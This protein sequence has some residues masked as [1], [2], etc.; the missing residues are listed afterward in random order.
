MHSVSGGT[1]QRISR[2]NLSK[3]RGR[4]IDGIQKLNETYLTFR[5]HSIHAGMAYLTIQIAEE[6]NADMLDH[7]EQLLADLVKERTGLDVIRDALS[8]Q[9]IEIRSKIATI[10]Q[11]IAS[12]HHDHATSI[13]G[14]TN[15][16]MVNLAYLTEVAKEIIHQGNQCQA[17][18]REEGA[19]AIGI[20][21]DKTRL[22]IENHVKNKDAALIKIKTYIA[23]IENQTHHQIDQINQHTID[24]IN[25]LIQIDHDEKDKMK[26]AHNTFFQ[27]QFDANLLPHFNRL[28]TAL[29]QEISKLDGGGTITAIPPVLIKDANGLFRIQNGRFS[30]DA[31]GIKDPRFWDIFGAAMI[32]LALVAAGIA[33]MVVSAGMAAPAL[34]TTIALGAAAGAGLG[35]GLAGAIYTIKGGVNQDFQWKDFGK[36]VGISAAAGA[37]GGAVTA[38]MGG[39]FISSSTSVLGRIGI[40]AG[41][42]S[43]GGMASKVTANAIT[44]QPLDDGLLTAGLAGAAGGALGA[45]GGEALRHFNVTHMGAHIGTGITSGATGGAGGELIA[46][47]IEGRA[48]DVNTMLQ[49][50]IS[51]GIVGGIGG[52]IAARQI[53]K[54]RANTTDRSENEQIAKA[55]QRPLPESDAALQPTIPRGG[56]R[57]ETLKPRQPVGDDAIDHGL[58]PQSKATQSGMTQDDMVPMAR[59]M[60][61]RAK[62]T[63]LHQE[64]VHQEYPPGQAASHYRDGLPEGVGNYRSLHRGYVGDTPRNPHFE[65]FSEPLLTPEGQAYTNKLPRTATD[66]K[67]RP[68]ARIELPDVATANFIRNHVRILR[69]NEVMTDVAIAVHQNRGPNVERN[70]VVFVQNHN[71]RVDFINQ[72]FNANR[73]PQVAGAAP[74]INTPFL[75]PTG[76]GVVNTVR[77]LNT[78]VI[79]ATVGGPTITASLNVDHQ[80]SHLHGTVPSLPD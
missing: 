73:P 4:G 44:G 53:Q 77:D 14:L 28:H 76:L 8:A 63:T 50:V 6:M 71:E 65:H 72:I 1:T 30:V 16:L 3:F 58:L 68:S 21:S 2:I 41:A 59:E 48:V 46:A 60:D 17:E 45:A 57:A 66:P 34:L 13:D 64:W 42:G 29:E 20:I 40:M 36:T 75:L 26:S 22:D 18:I 70:T 56:P 69:R 74:N 9:Y 80:L 24:T 25:Q 49:A 31:K 32:S 78:G 52:V 37:V 67:N 62:S 15:T 10:H 35:G 79:T 7:Y 5:S 27:H 11:T 39:A 51:G 33:A 43:L 61:V 19:H 12:A 23:D 47:G 54:Q 38:G 55:L